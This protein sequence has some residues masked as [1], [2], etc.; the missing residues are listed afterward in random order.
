MIFSNDADTIKKCRYK[1]NH[2]RKYFTKRMAT[3]FFFENENYF[4]KEYCI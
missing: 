3:I 4:L 1:V 2:R